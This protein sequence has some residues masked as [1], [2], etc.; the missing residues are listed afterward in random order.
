MGMILLPAVKSD[1]ND[2]IELANVAYRGMGDE[3]AGVKASWNLEVGV[4][5]GQRMNLSLLE[6][7]L[8]AKAEGFLLVWREQPEGPLLGT[9]W[10]VPK[11]DGVWHLGLLT[12][13][14]A[15]QNAGMG[16]QLLEAAEGF[17][18]ERGGWK[19]SMTVLNVRDALMA[20]YE[21]RGYWAT[22]EREPFPYGDDRFGR[23]LRDD[24]E[25]V[26]FEKEIG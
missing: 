19:I 21:R 12:V 11:G 14:P 18:R 7:E 22:G 9:V 4:L 2:I 8:A 20:W 10:L 5:E 1:Y 16:R 3:A 25:F 17:V 26:V 13:R 23:P 6:E 15:L 24:L